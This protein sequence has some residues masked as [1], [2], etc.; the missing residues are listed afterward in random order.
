MPV[1]FDRF[2]FALQ[3]AY[4]TL[5]EEKQVLPVLGTLLQ[6]VYRIS[7]DIVKTLEDG[8]SFSDIQEI[9]K[10][11]PQFIGLTDKI[12]NIDEEEQKKIVRD[13]V[14]LIYVA[15]DRGE[16]GKQNNIDIPFVFGP[17][18][19]KVELTIIDLVTKSVVNAVYDYMKAK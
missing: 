12:D 8:V 10:M 16:D 5:F 7:E 18:E 13:I 9:S 2:D 17:I 3:K 1:T 19:R 4:D 14:L 6:D 15:L 11:V